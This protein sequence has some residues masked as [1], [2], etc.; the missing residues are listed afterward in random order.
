DGLVS[1]VQCLRD[2]QSALRGETEATVRFALQAREVVQLRRSLCTRLFFLQLN[3]ALF[4]SALLLNSLRHFAMPQSG[5]SAM[6]VPERAVRRIKPLFGIR[7][8]QLKP[9]EQSFC[10]LDF[11]LFFVERF[12]EPSPWILASRRPERADNFSQLARLKFLNLAL[13]IDD[14]S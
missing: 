7:Q 3:D 12:V 9:C 5:S 13:A 1:L 8:I 10:S 4:A 14:D 6:L 11:S 2:L